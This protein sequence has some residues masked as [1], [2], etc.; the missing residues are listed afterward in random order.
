MII[1]AAVLGLAYFLI[2]GFTAYTS[3]T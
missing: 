2:E 3:G 1:A